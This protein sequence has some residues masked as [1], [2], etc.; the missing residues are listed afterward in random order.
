[1]P[2][3]VARLGP[4]PLNLHLT[5]AAATLMSSPA[6]LPLLKSGSL[7]WSPAL[8]DQ[9]NALRQALDGRDAAPIEAELSA[10]I[11]QR[12]LEFL[13][14]LQ[15]YRQHPYSRAAAFE[16]A[17]L[18]QP[19]LAWQEGTTRLL[20]YTAKR[21]KSGRPVLAVPSL[22]N[23]AYILDLAPGRSFMRHLAARGLRPYLVDWDA[24]GEIER[25]FDM[26]DYIAGR[27]ERALDAVLA[28]TGEKPV[29]IG[30]CMGGTMTAAL[31]AR[32]QQDMAGLVLLA[33]PWDFHADKPAIAEWLPALLPGLLA[34]AD[35]LGE[36]PIDSVQAL[37]S[38]LDIHLAF[39]KFRS[40]AALDPTSDKA[41]AFVALEDWLNDG[42]PL[43]APV[44]RDCLEGW[45][46]R[47]D[48]AT[49][50]WCITGKTVDPAGIEVPTLAL[51]PGT[52][53]IVPP[54]SAHALADA[55]AQA[56]VL[57]PP[58]G[59]I[60]MMVGGRAERGVWSPMLDW[61]AGL[62]KPTP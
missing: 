45:Y 61:I 16:A 26:S 9:A 20:G 50:A 21:R 15:A 33:A 58:L 14:G 17:G 54:A 25:G 10:A 52:D 55:I 13:N 42:V 18:P 3:P 2:P 41:T 62:P 47:N 59:H 1:M 29:V 24:P 57:E 11:R 12:W 35:R 36:L 49:G 22:I 8:K 38:G 23:R 37:F 40:F 43:S 31:A 51:I 5:I 19:R 46:G 6:A 48:T 53:R 4:R 32:R 28:E 7:S 56:T 34:S 44:A 60:G 39:R 30:Y 27:L